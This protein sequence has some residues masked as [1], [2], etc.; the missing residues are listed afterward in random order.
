MQIKMNVD[1]SQVKWEKIL[2]ASARKKKI[3]LYSSGKYAMKTADRMIKKPGKGKGTQVSKP[4]KPP[5]YHVRPGLKGNMLFEV[6]EKDSSVRIGPRQFATSPQVQIA[7]AS[8]AELLEFGGKI[9][10]TN[11]RGETKVGFIEARPYM[12]PAFEK[13]VDFFYKKIVSVPLK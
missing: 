7:A 11:R 6:N 8:G 12:A 2:K 4:G 13:A 1:T 3:I 9:S 10:Q 5:R